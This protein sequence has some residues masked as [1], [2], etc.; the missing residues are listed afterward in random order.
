MLKRFCEEE[1][2]G[3]PLSEQQKKELLA[4]MDMR[5]EDID[6]SD[7]PEVREIPPGAVRG[8][9]FRPGTV[10]HVPVYLNLDLQ[11][12]LLAAAERKGITL[13]DL[14]ND[15]LSKEIAIVETIR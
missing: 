4:L 3:K 13:S 12:Y 5:D 9:D 2:L 1:L 11:S 7:I 14:V 6:T 8:K 15:L 10:P